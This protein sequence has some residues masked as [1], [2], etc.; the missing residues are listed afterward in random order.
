MKVSVKWIDVEATK[1]E[2]E[3]FARAAESVA[4]VFV[5][6]AEFLAEFR[7]ICEDDSGEDAQAEAVEAI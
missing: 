7:R 2:L 1:E 6:G 4:S 5:K 3:I